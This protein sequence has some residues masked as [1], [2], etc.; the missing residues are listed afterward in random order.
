MKP[1]ELFRFL[2]RVDDRPIP[3]VVKLALGMPLKPEEFR[4]QKFLDL[5]MTQ[6][7]SLP[8]GLHVGDSLFLIDARNITRLPGMHIEGL[9]ALVGSNIKEIDPTFECQ[10]LILWNTPFANAWIIQHEENTKK[11]FHETYPGVQNVYFTPRPWRKIGQ[12]KYKSW[13]DT[14][15]S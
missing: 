4:I 3:V 12:M 15:F 11:A 7:R 10:F 6:V 2:E 13:R 8:P 1:I 5:S 9:A 14:K